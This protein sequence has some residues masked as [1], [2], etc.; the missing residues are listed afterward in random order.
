MTKSFPKGFLWGAAASAPQTEGGANLGG[1]SPSTWDVWFEKEPERFFNQVGPSNT[2]DV[3]HRYAEDAGHMK[4][5]NLNSYRTSIAW[6][7]L[8]P[9]GKTLNPEAVAYYRDYFQTLRDNGV[10]PV[11]NLFH[12]DMPWWMME[13]G[14]WENR[15]IVD[16]FAYYADQAFQAFGDLV[17]KWATFNEPMVHIECGYLGDAHWPMVNDMKRAVQVGYHTLLAHFAAVKAFREGNYDGEIGT[18]LNL[19]PVYPKDDAPENIEAKEIGE[20]IYIK[21]LLDP[22]VLGHFNPRLTAILK[23]NDLMPNKEAHDDDYLNY[24]IDFL[25]VNYYQPVRVQHQLEG[26]RPI[27]SRGDLVRGYN[28]PDKKMNPH[29][30][31]EIYEKG[32]YDIGMTI[33][34]DYGNIPWFISEN[35]MGVEGEEKFADADGI[36]QDDYRIE[37]IEGHLSW[38]HQAIE[39]GS[40]CFGYHLWTFVDCWSWLNAYKNRYGFYR[41]DL[42]QDGKRI[43]KQSSFW[44]AD[45]IKNNALPK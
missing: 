10:E 12:F 37:F 35:G 4:A 28:W 27:E 33:K 14:G 30:G 19:S 34:N 31:W 9:D 32:I 21:S 42:E 29:R 26:K 7:R 6:T 15:E 25:G 40:N 8:L 43:P 36:I 22:I 24:R 20:A 3:Y 41:I 18:I 5:M 2:S 45:V 1:K 38:L 39:E 16:H 23:E 17:K 44:M 13:K 11:I